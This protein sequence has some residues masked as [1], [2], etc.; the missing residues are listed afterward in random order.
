MASDVS[1]PKIAVYRISIR[2]VSNCKCLFIQ[3]G[4]YAVYDCILH[5]SVEKDQFYEWPDLRMQ[6]AL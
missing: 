1:N 2:L 3:A 4:L 5:Y 6:A